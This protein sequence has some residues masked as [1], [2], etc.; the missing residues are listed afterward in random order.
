MPKSL[1]LEMNTFYLVGWIEQTSPVDF[2]SHV[3]MDNSVYLGDG[4]EHVYSCG[5]NEDYGVDRGVR[6]TLFYIRAI[7]LAMQMAV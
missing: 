6:L 2:V 3:V 1:T 7:N 4:T 5:T